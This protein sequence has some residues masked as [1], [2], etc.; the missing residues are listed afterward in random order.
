MP[1]AGVRIAPVILGE[2]SFAEAQLARLAT[3][4]RSHVLTRRG[5]GGLEVPR[6]RGGVD[7]GLADVVVSLAVFAHLRAIDRPD[8]LPIGGFLDVLRLLGICAGVEA[9]VG[10]PQGN[11]R[12]GC[13]ILGYRDLHLRVAEPSTGPCD[14]VVYRLF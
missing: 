12:D 11:A 9:Q 5:A 1:L 7:E 14:N 4:S 6:D 13:E 10:V 8:P 2:A 3:N